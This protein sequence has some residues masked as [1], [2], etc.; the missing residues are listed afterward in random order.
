MEGQFVVEYKKK[1]R[2]LREERQSIVIG[3]SLGN[4]LKKTLNFSTQTSMKGQPVVEDKKK[5]RNLREERQSIVMGK[6][7]ENFF[8]K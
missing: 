7:L 5:K 2:N 1:E 8:K 4:F 3:K 6:S